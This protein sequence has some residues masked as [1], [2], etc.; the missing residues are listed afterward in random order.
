MRYVALLLA[1][2]EPAALST[3]W[4]AGAIVGYTR[5]RHLE[6]VS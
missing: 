5:D 2:V 3:S 1:V 6:Q 4:L